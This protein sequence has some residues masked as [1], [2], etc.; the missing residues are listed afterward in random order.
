MS[1]ELPEFRFYLDPAAKAAGASFA[2]PREGDAGF[3]LR[4]AEGMIIEAGKQALIPTGLRLHIPLGWVGIVKDRSS[5]ALKR[6]YTHAGVVDAGYRGEVKI[7]ISNFGEESYHVEPGAKIAQ[8]LILPHLHAAA[9]VTSEKELGETTRG[10]G[11][12][13][14]T[15]R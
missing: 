8:L 15:G 10:A 1:S 13:G 14:S 2:S 9:E 11:G 3:D 4:A 6:I 5:M 7:V 12:F